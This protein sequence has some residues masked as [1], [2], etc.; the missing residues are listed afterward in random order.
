[1][2]AEVL[3]LVLRLN[4]IS[5]DQRSLVGG[6][7][8]NLAVLVGAGLSVPAGFCVTTAAFDQFL[9]ACP[10][11]DQLAEILARLGAAPTSA[12]A[13]L[14]R[15][16]QACLGEVGVPSAVRDAVLTAWRQLGEERSYAVRSSATVEDAHD[17]SFAG[18]FQSI[19]NVR[20]AEPLLGALESCWRSRFAERALAYQ[21]RQRVP[22]GDV[23]MAVLVQEMVAADTSGVVFTADPLTGMADRCVVE[24]VRGLGEMLVQGTVRPERIVVAKTTRTV[25]ASPASEAARAEHLASEPNLDRLIHIAG[26]V[27]QLFGSPQ[28][29][30]WAQKD[31]EVFLLQS[32]PITKP[33]RPSRGEGR[34]WSNLNAAEN[35]Q[36]VVTPMSWSFLDSC[37]HRI[38][39]PLLQSLGTDPIREPWLGLIAGRVYMNV[40]TWRRVLDSLPG[41]RQMQFGWFFGG[42]QDALL[43]P[44]GTRRRHDDG[45]L[46]SGT[47]SRGRSRLVAC[48]RWVWMRTTWRSRE[49]CLARLRETVGQ[50]MQVDCR[51]LPDDEL[52]AHLN[53]ILEY[54]YARFQ[55]P[56]RLGVG[57]GMSLALWRCCAKW[58]NDSDG[59]LASRLISRAGGMASAD[60][61]L[62]LWRMAHWT[63]QHQTLQE[64]VLAERSFAELAG[65]LASKEDGRTF[66]QHW[67]TFMARHG[68]RARGEVDLAA[69]RWSET[70]DEVLRMLQHYLNS[71]GQLDLLQ[72]LEER[73]R[74]RDRALAE[75]RARLRNPLRRWALSALVRQAQK[76]IVFRENFKNEL[77]RLLLYLRQLLLE[78]GE[79]MA[80]A[81]ILDEPEAIF[82]LT[83][84]ELEPARTGAAAFD[85]RAVIR[86]R[87]DEF[88][89]NHT[90]TPPPVM[91]GEFD[92]ARH[93][94]PRADQGMREL[95][96]LPVSA[97]VATGPARVIL[98]ADATERVFP[99]EILVAPF[100]DPGWTPYFLTAAGLV[101]D[102]GGQLSHGSVVAR[103]YG[104][105]AVVNVQF[106][107]QLIRTGQLIRVDGDRGT[108]AVLSEVP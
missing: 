23:S 14:S 66:L 87:R 70:P 34:I 42:F 99:G 2:S 47:R 52:T 102:L 92:P 68:H 29:I 60:A 33:D 16:A 76:G 17:R 107:T 19:L 71:I 3:P 44:E 83:L 57:L 37:F 20:G 36:D 97:G 101:T 91:V 18:Q 98:R 26:Q 4:E 9:A 54:G 103:E 30:E 10:K 82:F 41:G 105:P 6:K 64:T 32:R 78:L 48:L 80:R 75:C 89:R 59:V 61:A 51:N 24:W 39:D 45:G 50:F 22:V 35:F 65:L 62:E 104:L 28:D 11:R 27:E 49:V 1:V 8:A 7:A 67:K 94:P 53:R 84:E 85:V 15:Q 93:V 77:L 74:E 31:G 21:V 40:S 86:A 95:R 108:V 106:A 90:L 38:G 12:I 46:S 56:A 72:V 63:S 79:R 25:L 69:R 58:F 43:S 55:L 96:G 81:G 88:Q 73:S 13:D 5:G 100:T